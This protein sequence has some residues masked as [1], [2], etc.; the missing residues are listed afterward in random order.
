MH[1]ALLE[2]VHASVSVAI[3]R[4]PRSGVQG[5]GTLPDLSQEEGVLRSD[6]KGGYLTM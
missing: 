1:T 4:C 5:R 6:V 2:T 3:T